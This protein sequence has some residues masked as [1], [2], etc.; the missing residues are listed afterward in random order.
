MP[1]RERGARGTARLTVPGT[2]ST[3]LEP[4]DPLER[5]RLLERIRDAVLSGTTGPGAPRDVV[6]ASWQRSLDAHIDPER[7]RPQ[8]VYEDDELRDVRGCHLLAPVLP[9][10]R[11]TLLDVA[12]DAVHMMIVTDVRG[13]ILWREGNRTVLRRAEQFELVEGTRWSEDSVGT[14]A[15][16]TALASGNAVQ[17]HSAEHL[18]KLYHSWTCAAAPIH[19]PDSGEVVA[20]IDLTGPLQTFHPST[21]ALVKAAAEL[22]EVHLRARLVERDERL[23]HR[24]LPHLEGLRGAPGALLAPGGRVITTQSADWLPERLDIPDG[25][26]RVDLG[27]RREGVVEPLAEGWLL[28]LAPRAAQGPTLS[29]TFLGA[30]R[31]V[32]RLDGRPVRLSLR[33]AEMLVVLALHPDGLTAD[34]LAQALYGDAGNPVT[35]RSEVH[36]LRN[37]LGSS[38]ISTQPYRL[39]ARVDA[40]F[41]DVRAALRDRRLPPPA[42]LRRGPLLPTS[43]APGVREERDHLDVAV[44]S[45]VLRR[46]DV[47]ALWALAGA[48]GTD[49]ELAER[50]RLLLPD[51]D[52]RR[53]ELAGR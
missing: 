7:G 22:A 33:H 12:D 15:M 47:E 29:L 38:I 48:A 23:R 30:E 49:P 11:R 51:G 4:S 46:G 35:V 32:A 17:I 42:V 36:R 44:R 6:S 28:R 9:L 1:E 34:G 10:L 18:V 43:D 25:G 26:G 27:E 37:A 19:D 3:R 21:L 13:H 50:L 40:D 14:N 31:P 39:R 45:A 52:P 20:A 16:G 5:A 41:L 53:D 2:L 24:N 8:H